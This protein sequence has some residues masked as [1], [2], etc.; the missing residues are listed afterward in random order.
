MNINM[1]KV[2]IFFILLT[3][4]FSNISLVFASSNSP[5]LVSEAAI[6]I[7][8]TTGKILYEKNK[9]KR[10]YP[11]STT[12][13]LTAI[14]TLENCKL[15]DVITVSYDSVMSIPDGYVTANL[16]I[17]EEL[18]VRQLLQVLLVH[19][20]NDAANVLAEHVGGSVDSF[21]SMMNTKVSELGLSNTHFTNTYGKHDDNHYTTASDLAMIMKY[22]IRNEDFR[23]LAGS[24][25]CAIP[26]TNKY[27]TRLYTSTNELIIPNNKNYYSFLTS[28]KTGF[29]TEAGD[30]LVSCGYKNDCEFICVVLGGK[31]IDNVSTRFSETKKLYEYG[32]SNYSKKEIVI[33]D[34]VVTSIEISGATKDTKNLNLLAKNSITSLIS[35]DSLDNELIPEITLNENIKAPIEQDVVLGTARYSIDGIDYS[36]ELISANPVQKSY[37]FIISLQIAIVLFFIFVIYRFKISK[38]KKRK[39]KKVNYE[40]Y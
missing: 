27:G 31:T 22:C 6:L 34:N 28:G 29:T 16:Q 17:N 18:T 8:N 1:K 36:V 15:D 24:A 5:E 7:D 23:K 30:C 33:Q 39:R 35:N 38:N 26:K 11:A 32:F 3:L 12:K 10:M 13:I 9:D 21:V 19:S 20:A 37:I 14:L 25:S 4:F 40:Y 2:F